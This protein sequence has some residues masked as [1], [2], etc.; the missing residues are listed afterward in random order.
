MTLLPNW[1]SDHRAKQLAAFSAAAQ[2]FALF[3]AGFWAL[4]TWWDSYSL[5]KIPSIQMGIDASAQWSESYRACRGVFRVTVENAG[6]RPVN[7]PLPTYSMAAVKTP[8]LSENQRFLILGIVKAV[9]DAKQGRLDNL[10]GTYFPKEKRFAE[11]HFLFA[12]D[13]ARLQTIETQIPAADDSA[14]PVGGYATVESCE[15]SR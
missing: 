9:E 3:V 10:S 6:Q 7:V 11:V 5:S 1:P 8:R 13:R 14:K 15:P 4:G 12:P 2:I